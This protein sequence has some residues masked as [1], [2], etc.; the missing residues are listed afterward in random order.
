MI[1]TP[2]RAASVLAFVIVAGASA[3]AQIIAIQRPPA[4]LDYATA[5]PQLFST[6][7]ASSDFEGSR[8]VP[9]LD[10]SDSYAFWSCR[11][12]FA[13][14][15]EVR[16]ER[17][18]DGIAV[19]E[20]RAGVFERVDYTH[21]ESWARAHS[22]FGSNR[23]EAYAINSFTWTE[24]RVQSAWEPQESSID[25]ASSA[26]AV[27]TSLWTE[28]FVPSANG[29]VTLEF[30]LRQHVLGLLPGFSLPGPSEPFQGDG[31][32]TL[33]VQVF[34]LDRTV[35]YDRGD[36]AFVDGPALLA[37][38]GLSRIPGDGAGSSF[39]QL[40]LDLNAGTNYVLVSRLSLS[41]F[42]NARIDMYG[43][44]ELE[45]ILVAPGQSL[46]FTS[47]TA[48]NVSVVPE[49]SAWGL[50]LAG[51][52]LVATRVARPAQRGKGR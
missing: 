42:N 33:E 41:A 16:V 22:G 12:L 21:A 39:M 34:D 51:M 36:G 52:A 25:G 20:R 13:D 29:P 37:S 45:R 3:H 49:P 15:G 50:M 47:G 8:R 44:V 48:Y 5:T 43:T 14:E 23:A 35:S 38:E 4:L 32:G 31:E 7:A 26:Y 6:A 2:L 19:A 11:E 24:R 30:V 18:D 9:P 10:C 27:A 40:S 28:A 1:S 46:A 17:Q